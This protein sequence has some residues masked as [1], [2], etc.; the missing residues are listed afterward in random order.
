MVDS[1]KRKIGWELLVA[2][3]GPSIKTLSALTRMQPSRNPL[4]NRL[5]ISSI[6]EDR[7]LMNAHNL[8]SADQR[9]FN[10]NRVRGGMVKLQKASAREKKAQTAQATALIPKTRY[11]ASLRGRKSE[12][13]TRIASTDLEG[14]L[15]TKIVNSLKRVLM[16]TKQTTQ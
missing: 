3:N 6:R 13:L 9:Q 14:S 16:L 8:T 12:V 4:S 10:S 15:S 5:L 2:R 1:I 7:S 11:L